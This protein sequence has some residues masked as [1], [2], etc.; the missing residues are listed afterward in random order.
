MLNSIQ[1]AWSITSLFRPRSVERELNG[2]VWLLPPRR[3]HLQDAFVLY[4]PA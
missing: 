3:V 1:S 2:L 4:R